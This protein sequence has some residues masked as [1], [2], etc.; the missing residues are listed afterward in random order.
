[1][2]DCRHVSGEGVHTEGFPCQADVHGPLYYGRDQVSALLSPCPCHVIV[3]FQSSTD[4]SS[5]T[6]ATIEVMSHNGKIKKGGLDQ[7]MCIS[8]IFCVLSIVCLVYVCVLVHMC[9]WDIYS[10][11]ASQ[12]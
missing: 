8:L 4:Q 6:T 9:I 11:F 12:C 5:K 7:V 3:R 2:C 1:M 10:D